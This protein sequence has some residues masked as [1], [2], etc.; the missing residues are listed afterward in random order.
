MLK[1]IAMGKEEDDQWYIIEKTT[2]K[3]GPYMAAWWVSQNE[4]G[5]NLWEFPFLW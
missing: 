3:K 4:K 1:A 5:Y 2:K